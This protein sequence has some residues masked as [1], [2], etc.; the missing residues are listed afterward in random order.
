[1]PDGANA[2]APGH[3]EITEA[4]STGGAETRRRRA[5]PRGMAPRSTGGG[6]S[7]DDTAS[8]AA[9]AGSACTAGK[10]EGEPAAPSGSTTH[11]AGREGGERPRAHALAA[12]PA[13]SPKGPAAVATAAAVNP[14]TECATALTATCAATLAPV[15]R[16]RL[17]E[18]AITRLRRGHLP[19]PLLPTSSSSFVS[20]ISERERP[21]REK[22]PKRRGQRE[23]AGAPIATE[24]LRVGARGGAGSTSPETTPVAN[25]VPRA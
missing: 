16:A 11:A 12:P 19:R 21:P 15:L 23:T 7:E 14:V 9:S 1:M 3:R 18:G 8:S 5:P 2:A 20:A 22:T 10:G 13:S 24:D 25:R 6:S 4:R 17:T